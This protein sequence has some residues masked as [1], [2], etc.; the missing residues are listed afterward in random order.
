MSCP[1]NWPKDICYL[2]PQ[3]FK[4]NVSEL[5]NN[6]LCAPNFSYCHIP[7]GKSSGYKNEVNIHENHLKNLK[8]E[9]DLKGTNKYTYCYAPD[10]K[11]K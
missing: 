2:K 7:D 8:C 10:M 4:I 11:F 9:N 5:P 1:Q 3:D 6:A